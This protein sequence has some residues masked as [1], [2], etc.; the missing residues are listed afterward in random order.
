MQKI[1]TKE[2]LLIEITTEKLKIKYNNEFW[3]RIYQIQNQ[4]KKVMIN[5]ETT[6]NYYGINDIILNEEIIT[7][8]RLFLDIL[9]YES[10]LGFTFKNKKGKITGEQLYYLTIS[11]EEME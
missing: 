10:Y 2:Q 4:I 6:F 8:L 11:W 5:N 7:D 3:E 1:L 9:G